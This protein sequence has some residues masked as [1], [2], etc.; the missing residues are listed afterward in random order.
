MRVGAT[1][2]GTSPSQSVLWM[3]NLALEADPSSE[4]RSPSTSSNIKS[5]TRKRS[6]TRSHRRRPLLGRSRLEDEI[7]QSNNTKEFMAL[8]TDGRPETGLHERS[9]YPVYYNYSK[10]T[11]E[12]H[13][14]IFLAV[15]FALVAVALARPDNL[16][17]YSY[18]PP[19]QEDSHESLDIFET[20]KYEFTHA[21]KD[22]ETANDFGH[23]EARDDENTQ[24]SYFVQL[25]DGRLQKVTYYVDGDSGFIAEVSYEGEARYPEPD[26]SEERT[27]YAPPPPRNLYGAPN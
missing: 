23:Q 17:T 6:F 13:T 3:V 7:H 8:L 18:S 15:V 11:Q 27:V 2:S 25:P 9:L 24:G 10:Y 26:S 19:S 4:T 21:V 16:P 14:E 1:S 22:E 5:S 20:P 12:M